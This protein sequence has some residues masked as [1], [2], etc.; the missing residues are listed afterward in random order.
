MQRGAILALGRVGTGHLL[1]CGELDSCKS[2]RRRQV[3]KK[4]PPEL[5]IRAT[6]L[7][8]QSLTKVFF[9]RLKSF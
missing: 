9:S 1:S 4:N 2:L 5:W 7:Y 6:G 3:M 8:G